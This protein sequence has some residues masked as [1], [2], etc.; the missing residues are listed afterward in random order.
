MQGFASI[1]RE[2]MAEYGATIDQAAMI[3]V[4]NHFNGSLNRYA[5]FQKPVT[6][7]E[8]QRAKMVADPLTVL[9]CSPWDEGAAAVVLCAAETAY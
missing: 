6:I 5:H 4:K 2:Y 3:S 9:H 7:E 8:V 1:A